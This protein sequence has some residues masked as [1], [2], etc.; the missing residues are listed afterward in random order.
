M[1]CGLAL[2][3]QITAAALMCRWFSRSRGVALGIVALGTQAGG[4]FFPPVV[5]SLMTA[6][7]WRV[8]L[9]SVGVFVLVGAPLIIRFM[10]YDHPRDKGL[11]P[12]APAS[13]E[14]EGAEAARLGRQADEEI[15]SAKLL[16]SPILWLVVL[17]VS[18]SAGTNFALIGNLATFATD[19]GESLERGAGLISVFAVAGIFS[20]PLFGRITDR[21]DSRLAAAAALMMTAA[22]LMLFI[23]ADSYAMLVAAALLLGLGGGATF[24]LWAAM[25]GAFFPTRTVG[26]ALG[27]STLFANPAMAFFA[28]FSGWSYDVTQSYRTV[29]SVMMG[30]CLVAATMALCSR[31]NVYPFRAPPLGRPAE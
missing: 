30:L 8:A 6:F 15:T 1:S 26:R 2:L 3:G 31:F 21:A 5:A 9:A 28:V 11:E 29:L 13:D 23:L 14:V 4:F 18:A 12:E 20:S 25:I 19:L 22:S 27:L 7:G 24:P 16:R 10:I 17:F